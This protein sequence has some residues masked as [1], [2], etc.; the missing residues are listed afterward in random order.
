M[1]EVL[2]RHG[3]EIQSQEKNKVPTNNK[4][5][6]Y[7]RFGIGTEPTNVFYEGGSLSG[8]FDLVCQKGSSSRIGRSGV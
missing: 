1:L 7:E 8:K 3:I 2:N 4:H 5:L 6:K